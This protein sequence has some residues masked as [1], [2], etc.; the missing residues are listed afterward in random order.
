[1]LLIICLC[2]A[3]A[4]KSQFQHSSCNAEVLGFS[5]QTDTCKP[6]IAPTPKTH[7]GPGVV[8]VQNFLMLVSGQCKVNFISESI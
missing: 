3:H 8:L 6:E 7:L 1:M 5:T 4:C 2:Y